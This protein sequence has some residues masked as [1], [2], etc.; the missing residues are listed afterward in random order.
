MS[1][2]AGARTYGGID[3]A[4][5]LPSSP[6]RN[7]GLLPER[8]LWA[9]VFDRAL[10]D[11]E[12]RRSVVCREDARDWFTGRGGDHRWPFEWVCRVLG[13]DADAVRKELRGKGLL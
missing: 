6:P 10:E 5:G 8:S 13:L 2:G 7:A 3:A 4:G 9:A 11:L 12:N 1:D